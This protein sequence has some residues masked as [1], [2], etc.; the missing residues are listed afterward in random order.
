[1]TR[2]AILVVVS[3]S[4][5]GCSTTIR[6]GLP[7]GH[8]APGY[9]ERWNHGFVVGLIDAS[10]PH[11]LARICPAGW[12]EVRTE[13]SILNAFV[14]YATLAIYAPQSVTIVCAGAG[15]DDRTP[16]P[17]TY[18]VAIEAGVHPPPPA[19]R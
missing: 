17:A 11:D 4:L 2:G 12:A 1:M 5:F 6:S 7:P 15:R 19:L 18:P 3:A 14:Q 13:T 16:P 9:D 8:V 10:G